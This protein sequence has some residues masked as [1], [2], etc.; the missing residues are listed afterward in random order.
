MMTC[1]PHLKVDLT[2]MHGECLTPF[3]G[4]LHTLAQ[5]WP[6]V[7]GRLRTVRPIPEWERTRLLG[8]RKVHARGHVYAQVGGHSLLELDR[9]NFG[10]PDRFYEALARNNVDGWSP[11][12]C[13]TIQAVAS[14]EFGHLLDDW[15]TSAYWGE[16][17]NEP[18]AIPY[19]TAFSPYASMWQEFG[20][21]RTTV[22]RFKHTVQQRQLSGYASKRR[23]DADSRAGE[24]FAEGFASY[25]HT[26]AA[27]RNPY[28][29]KLGALLEAV[30]RSNWHGEGEF[31]FLHTLEGEARER[32]VEALAGYAKSFGMRVTL[33]K[34][35]SEALAA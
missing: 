16:H 19:S 12:G 20:L 35:K 24:R 5:R 15:L 18:E 9:V 3:L 23:H 33:L 1:W 10:D 2:G 13:S 8:G 7:M 34:P 21:V 32:G 25:I 14:H 28:A 30:D 4:Q 17:A 26:P 29:I 27:R 31:V 11:W 22:A 6:E